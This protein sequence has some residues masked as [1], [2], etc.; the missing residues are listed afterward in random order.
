MSQV[1]LIKMNKG[2][3]KTMLTAVSSTTTSAE[4]RISG[5]NAVLVTVLINGAGTWK[6]DIQGRLDASGTVM[7]IVDNNDAPLTTGNLTVS[8][9]KL[10]V[11]VPD[12]IT[13]VATEIADGA[14]CT[15]RIQPLNV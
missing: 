2:N 9:M 6:V 8:T 4:E 3:V 15:V 11:S 5:Y 12:L 7:P 1:D 13:V 10:F 14:T